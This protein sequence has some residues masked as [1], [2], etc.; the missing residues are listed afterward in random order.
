ME[1][2]IFNEQN[3]QTFVTDRKH[4]VISV[5]DPNYEFV[6]LPKQD[7]RLA[8]IGLKFHDLDTDIFPEV[9]EKN[10]NFVLFNRYHI[11]TIFN[12]VNEWKD[13]VDLICINC[14]AGISRSMAVGAAL[15]KILNN[16]D[17][18]FFENGLPN[19]RVY[20]TILNEYYGSNF[21][22][23]NKREIPNNSDIGFI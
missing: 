2:K 14:V 20:R 1:I 19:M 12:F 9:P 6:K 15:G 3:I 7:S 5:Q 4:I 22:D 13:K 8:W 18:W 10:K 17:S 16:D 21:N 11:I 23:F